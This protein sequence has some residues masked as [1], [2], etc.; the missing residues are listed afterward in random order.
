MGDAL[1]ALRSPHAPPPAA[2]ATGARPRALNVLGMFAHHPELARALFTFNAH[3]LWS[4]SLS[5]RD[6]ELVILRVAAVRDAEYEF[7][8]HVVQG[9]SAGLSGTEIERV[10]AGPTEPGWTD[11][12]VALLAAVDELL[13]DAR[14]GDATWTALSS[15]RDTRQMMDLVFTVGAYELLAMAFRTFDLELDADLLETSPRLGA[16]RR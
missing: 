9:R 16:V 11:D 14:I 7:A 12:E 4:S 15:R 2:T 5:D 1:A 6:R 3:L 13:A 10:V 8:Q